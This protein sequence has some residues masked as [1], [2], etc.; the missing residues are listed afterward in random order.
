MI[1]EYS[2]PF[3]KVAKKLSGKRLESLKR[4]ITEVQKA[5]SVSEITDCKKMVGYAN[6]YR[7][8]L[9]D[10]RALFGLHIHIEGKVAYFEYLLPRG[11]AY[12]KEI[13]KILQQKDKKGMKL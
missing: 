5:K 8:R 10:Y 1:V 13:L 4:V 3:V 11:Q 9:G 12:S 6:T 2:K 7:I